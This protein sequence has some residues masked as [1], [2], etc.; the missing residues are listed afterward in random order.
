M[1]AELKKE[2]IQVA[3]LCTEA[4]CIL[5]TADVL[6]GVDWSTVDGLT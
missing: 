4:S 5:A 1:V 2:G 6:V 3:T